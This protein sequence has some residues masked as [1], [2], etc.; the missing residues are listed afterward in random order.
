[1][2]LLLVGCNK[3]L[4]EYPKELKQFH[5]IIIP[6]QPLSAELDEMVINV[7]DI[8]RDIKKIECLQFDV[9]QVNPYQFD[10]K[11]VV[12]LSQCHEVAGYKPDENVK[13][14]NW[15]DDV[16]RKAEQNGCFK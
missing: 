12:D 3:G 1:M 10:F 13:L 16:F 15:I 11:G 8:P 9:V 7:Q 5:M 14:W 4:P 6:N 2:T